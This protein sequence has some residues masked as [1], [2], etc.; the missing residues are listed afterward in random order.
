MEQQNDGGCPRVNCCSSSLARS[1]M[2]ILLIHAGFFR[3]VLNSNNVK[4]KVKPQ[5]FSIIRR[6]CEGNLT[7][8]FTAH[9]NVVCEEV[10]GREAAGSCRW[11]LV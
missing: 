3:V 10:E 5:L 9:S 8:S 1:P 4:A 7:K 11:E 6:K 2:C